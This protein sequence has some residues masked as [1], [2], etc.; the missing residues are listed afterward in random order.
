MAHSILLAAMMANYIWHEGAG[1]FDFKLEVG[2]GLVLLVLVATI[3][4]LFFSPQLHHTRLLG[5]RNFGT[6]AMRY[7]RDFE[8]KWIR[9]ETAER[10]T[11]LG[12]GDIQSL[13]DLAGSYRVVQGMKLVPMGKETLLPLMVFLVLPFLPLTLTLIPL[14]ELANKILGAF[15]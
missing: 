3:P 6:F 1:V 13:A 5:M 2:G 9:G 12:S 8:R 10:E 14:N 15:I 4:L 11:P 7:V